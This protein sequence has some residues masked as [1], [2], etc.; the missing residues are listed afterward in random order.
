MMK[1]KSSRLRA[2]VVVTAALAILA[3]GGA[4]IASN[5]GF[6]LNQPEYPLAQVTNAVGDNW[7]SLPF[8]DPYQFISNFCT[9]TGLLT[10]VGSQALVTYIDPTT[11]V[12]KQAL[13]G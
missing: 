10:T 8:N 5:M 1:L 4:A 3:A 9:D 7:N 13:C 11:N 6:K 2:V 12:A